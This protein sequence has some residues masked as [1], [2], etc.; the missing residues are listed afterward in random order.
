MSPESGRYQGQGTEV[1][2]VR[3]SLAWGLFCLTRDLLAWLGRVPPEGLA[4]LGPHS[5]GYECLSV[6]LCGVR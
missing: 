2:W 6:Y 1:F 3:V 5:V 4:E